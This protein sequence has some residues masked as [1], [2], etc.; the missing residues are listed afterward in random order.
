MSD[1]T[2]NPVLHFGGELKRARLAAGLTL[3][4]V[5]RVTGY[6]KSQVSRVER[7]L[8]APTGKFAQGCDKAFPERG[9]WFHRF[10]LDSRQWSAMPPFEIHCLLP[11]IL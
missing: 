8:R 6:H 4:Q 11:L 9:G 2:S 3:A 7:G 5:A 1:D 10:Y